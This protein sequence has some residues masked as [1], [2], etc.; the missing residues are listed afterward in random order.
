M[1]SSSPIVCGVRTVDLQGGATALMSAAKHG[2][3]AVVQTLLERG[4]TVNHANTVGFVK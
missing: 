3:D 2:H 4:A 1:G